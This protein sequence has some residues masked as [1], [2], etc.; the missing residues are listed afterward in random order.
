MR[1]ADYIFKTLA[2]RGIRQVFV[3]T[4]GGA[5]H[6]NDA[7]GR[8]RRIQYVCP[9]HEQ[10][11]AFA[12]EGWARISGLPGVLSVTSGPG[13]TNALTGVAGAWLDSIP[14]IVISGQVKLAMTTS[15]CPELGLRQLGDQELNIVDV[16]RPITKYAVML[17]SAADIR[18]ELDKAWTLCRSGR[19]GPV[20]LDVPLDI[21]AAEIDPDK[22]QPWTPEPELPPPDPV[23]LRCVADRMAAARRPVIMAGLG[24]RHGHG[25]EML[26]TLAGQLNIPLLTAISGID[27]IDSGHRLFCGRPGI[28]GERAANFILQNADL[29]LV[30]GTR[31]G[32]RTIG[33][34]GTGTA[35]AAYKIMVD[36]DP[37]EL[38]KPTFRPDLAVNADAG[39]FLRA[40]VKRL[41]AAPENNPEWLAYCR[42]LREQ[43]P[44]ITAAHRNRTDY[45]SSYVLPELLSRFCPDDAIVV[46]GNGT[47]YTSTF[48]AIPLKTG[49]RMFANAACASMGYGLPAAIGAALAG[50]GR[51][52]LCLTGDGSLQ[53]NLQELQTLR[54]LNLPL[55]L[56][57]YNNAGYLSIKLTQRSFFN[58]HFVGSESG[59]G[60][61]LPDLE[62]L[63]GAYGL[64][65]RRLHCNREAEELLP[66]ILAESGPVVIEVMTDPFEVLGPKAATRQL[67]GGKL[68]SA[69]L[70]DLAPFLPREE[71]RHN[72]LI[73]PVKED[74]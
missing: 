6:L 50:G 74:F 52:V 27:L 53:M 17:R 24:V 58:G 11:G 31:M 13:G 25:V 51:E 3:V 23:V 55:K 68:V 72:M 8:E 67:P 59:S 57:V 61:T 28:L 30:I 12:A 66:E 62:R 7:L 71:F 60:V 49:M 47:A 20:W 18:R 56:F 22:L 42:R 9:L 2:D 38:R 39:E 64:P 33:Y 65:F 43:Y 5:M 69:P 35:R 19:P 48:Q 10:A 40:L 14:M 70:E 21:Q 1:V 32:I 16:V 37:A 73:D 46:T 54:R 44:I 34:S 29:L 26:K 45:V 4:G 15:V 41:P 36:A 63:A